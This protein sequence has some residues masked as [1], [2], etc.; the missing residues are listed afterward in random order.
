MSIRADQYHTACKKIRRNKQIFEACSALLK[1][2]L[3][4]MRLLKKEDN[5]DSKRITGEQTV[6]GDEE[7]DLGDT[8]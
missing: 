8:D 6:V 2:L 5:K 1:E 7:D 3:N 4:K